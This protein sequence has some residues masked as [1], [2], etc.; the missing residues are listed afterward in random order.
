LD[1]SRVNGWVFE[2]LLV[3]SHYD[4]TG[5]PVILTDL[6]PCIDCDNSMWLTPFPPVQG[7]PLNGDRVRLRHK[8]TG[9]CIYSL[10]SNG[11]KARNWDCWN[12]PG[13]V[14][15]LDDAGSGTFR[16]RHE[17]YGQCLYTQAW[18]GAS[19]HNWGCWNDPN[20]RFQLVSTTGG[21]RLKHVSNNQCLYGNTNNGGVVKSWGCW[22]DPNMV[23][24]IDIITP[25]TIWLDRD[26]PS[27]SG[28]WE[29]RS[30]FG[31]DVCSNPTAIQARRKS[32][33]LEAN[34]TGETFL[35]YNANNGFAC[36]NADQPDTWCFDYEVRF[37][38]Q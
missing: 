10:S 38:C 34:E 33:G 32:D 5:K 11:E 2:P 7:I 14:Y 28:D 30:G 8:Q 15:V 19:V 22:N 37:L 31:S 26:N 35:F 1:D 24:S 9:K 13:M 36:L 21:Y 23:Y 4:S 3:F 17:L 18:N 20:M 25:W 29:N 12:D 6:I 27:G 16:L